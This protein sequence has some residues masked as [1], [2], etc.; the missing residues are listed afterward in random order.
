MGVCA[1]LC[2]SVQRSV[3]FC[4]R[5]VF[6]TNEFVYNQTQNVCYVHIVP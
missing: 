4:V 6:I 2:G 5:L 3:V 1:F